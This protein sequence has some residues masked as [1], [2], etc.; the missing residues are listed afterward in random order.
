[1]T[2]GALP[3][4]VGALL[5]LT[6]QRIPV[7]QAPIGSAATP[8]LVGA[9]TRAGGM[10]GLAMTW[11]DPAAAVAKVR[12]TREATGGA[13]F[14]ANFVLHFPCEGFGA[15]LDAGV[16][17]VTLSWGLNAGMV[18]RAHRAG[19]KVG[20]QVG[21]ADGARRAREAGADF[22]IAQGV[23]AGGH[24]Q[25]TTP[26]A[27]LLPAVLAEA[28]GLPVIAAGGIASGAAIARVIAAGAAGA[29]MGTRFLASAEADVHADYQAALIAACSDDTA[30]TNCFDVG[31]PFAMH[32][33]LRNDTFKAWEAAGCPQPPARPGEGETVFRGVD[34]DFPRYSDTSPMPGATGALRSACLYAGAGVGDI[35][36][37]EPAEGLTVR[38]WAEARAELVRS[39]ERGRA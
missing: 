4:Q 35:R 3:E 39:P 24:V 20:I 1:M 16:P 11:S 17:I 23:E 13:A 19:A 27:T 6:G 8:A 36:S 15:A 37:V 32:R 5:A 34:E 21:N 2:G 29:M 25:S 28:G 33:V 31:W 26:L 9:V 18:A 12:A 7:V 22:L 10:G 38:L 14:F 30:F